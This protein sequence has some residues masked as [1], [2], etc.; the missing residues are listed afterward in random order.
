LLEPYPA[1]PKPSPTLV[2]LEIDSERVNEIL[3]QTPSLVNTKTLPVAWDFEEKHPES[4]RKIGNRVEFRVM[5]SEKGE[6]LALYYYDTYI[7]K[8][9]VARAHTVF[10]LDRAIFID[11]LARL[12]DDLEE[13]GIARAVFF[14]GPRSTE[15]VPAMGI[16]DEE[17]LDRRFVLLY[18]LMI[19]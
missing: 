6:N 12:I 11:I 7:R 5:V 2:P 15:W 4:I 18:E 9:E 14:I 3:I 8:G 16:L 13:S 19:N 1:H 10:S 17:A